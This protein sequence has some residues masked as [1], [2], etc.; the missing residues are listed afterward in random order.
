[1]AL[2]KL[3]P[4]GYEYLTG[5]VA[6]HDHPLEPGESLA[7]Y[8]LAHGYPPGQWFG[9]GAEQLGVTGEV[10]AAQMMALFGE[11]RHPLAD[12][13]EADL[14]AAG[15]SPE[16]ALTATKLGYRFPQY[17]G[18]DTLRRRVAQAYKDHNRATGRPDNAPLPDDVR[19]TIRRTV[20]ETAFTDA[21]QG[22][23]PADA[24]ELARWL[25][26]QK[27]EL[28]SAVAGYEAVFA[29]P[30]SVSVAWA[31]A[32]RATADTI[33]TAHRESV[34]DALR[35]LETNAAFTRKGSAGIAQVDV[36]GITAAQ[37][38]H[39]DSR[40]GD[41]HL[42][43]H[44]PI[45]TK[46]QN[47]A[48]EWTS[49]DGRSILAATVTISEYYNSR[50]RDHLRD[51]GATWIQRPTNG[52]DITRPVWELA[53]VP[54]ELIVA[55]SR[56]SAQVDAARAAGIVAFRNR[57]GHE[58]NPRE[59]LELGRRAQ[60]GTRT[61]KTAPRTLAQHRA[62]W[63]AFA[64]ETIGA[65]ARE[66][67]GHDVL[68]GRVA[69][70][71]EVNVA[72][73]AERTRHVVS[74]HRATFTRWNLEAEAHRQTAH[75]PLAPDTHAAAVT[76][77]VQAILDAED[78]VTLQA[79]TLVAEPAALRRRDGESVFT[80]HNATR[81]TTHTTLREEAALVAAAQR[82][83]G[84]R[85]DLATVAVA[86]DASARRGVH[87]NPAQQRLVAEFAASGRRVQL[88]LAPAGT[89]KTTAMRVFA[90]AWRA[91]GGRVFAFAPSARA[92]QELA[93]AIGARPHTLHQVPTALFHGTAQRSFGFRQGDVVI[94][95]EAA[96]SGTHTLHTVIH[97]V[98]DQGA[99]VRLVG[100]D[101][102]LAAVEA[103]GAIRLIAQDVGAL[104]LHE[105]VRFTDSDQ[106]TA[107]LQ[108]RE[109]HPHGLKYYLRKGW[110]EGG[111][112]ETMRDAAQQA[113]R[114]DLDA[115]LQSLLIAPALDDV[116]AL[117]LQ[118]R[119]QRAARGDID[120]HRDVALHDGTRAG[121]HD[122]IVTRHNDRTLTVLRGKDFVKNGD[123]WDVL[124]VSR[125]GELRVQHRTHGARA[126]LPARYVRTHVELAYAA[127]IHRVQGMTVA[128]RA[129]TVIPPGMTREQF[130]P[131]ITRAQGENRMYVVTTHHVADS[132]QETPDEVTARGVLTGILNR[133]GTEASATE[134]LRAA[135]HEE[136]SLATLVPRY[137][138]AA[139]LASTQRYK[140]LLSQHLPAALDAD[141][142][143]A[144]LQTMRTIDS[145]GW[146]A[147][148][149]IP[150][151]VA[152]HDFLDAQDPAAV[153]IHRVQRHTAAYRPPARIANPTTEEAQRWRA[154]VTKHN[155][156]LDV[157]DDR[158][159]TVCQHGAAGSLDAVDADTA[160]NHAALDVATQPTNGPV[161][162]HRA[163][164]S[165]VL[166]AQH[167]ERLS[168]NLALP[169]M[170]RHN[171]AALDPT[172][173]LDHYLTATNTTIATRTTEL[174][175]HVVHTQP[176]WAATLDTR[177]TDHHSAARW[178]RL[179]GL[180][181]AYRETFHITTTSPDQPLGPEPADTTPQAPAWRQITTMWEHI[182]TARNTPDS[183]T[184]E[185][186]IHQLYEQVNNHE[187]L[188]RRTAPRQRHH[189]DTPDDYEDADALDHHTSHHQGT[190]Y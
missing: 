123:T 59:L 182:T 67:L 155:P 18:E 37:F 8:Y 7:D 22:Q 78:T 81:Y 68:A 118:A 36:R 144:L 82:T 109:G 61:A 88:A 186:R 176:P 74:D 101:Q 27:R 55:F 103:G 99:D 56:R 140:N 52:I 143:P 70:A 6:C 97:H 117:N 51:A 154:I 190:G 21:H 89:G 172:T 150:M 76:S 86:L 43:T 34:T 107:S 23:A 96:M 31:L 50:L 58:P 17:G 30:K 104:R 100:D 72:E 179:I 178:D 62:R 189:T 20:T 130:Y 87:L 45:S 171:L 29:P 114:A 127:T 42:H 1:M 175:E 181:A 28:R 135:L 91:Q 145:I 5:T 57:H 85:V 113:W 25:A 48:G 147:E 138:H 166:A 129:H 90:D 152:V 174:V 24:A 106:A 146:Q 137:N 169:W 11:G 139:D 49:L 132:H 2:R 119:A 188:D 9:T 93:A 120:T 153:L 158:W 77:V 105:V 157:H 47:D 133:P 187:R 151:L 10:T 98:L 46:V 149:L 184:T 131:T 32:D 64:D 161:P 83:G 111:S 71:A 142:L 170:A 63:R 54:T 16:K 14:L 92:A 164:A 128:H 124:T 65:T 177:P 39:W 112:I 167:D 115:G 33:A 162:A 121:R 173:D 180:A 126:T 35:Y 141:A 44:V 26:E 122:W 19:A 41:P 148:R 73:L 53:G 40:T 94:I 3:T 66:Q 136:E 163:A 160:I 75:L 84:H 110:V 69:D 168:E 116:V 125:D 156:G 38:E 183:A 80:Q 15:T 134:Q 60:Y 159:A 108:I 185:L 4:G 95:D 79:P 12:S 13:I 102:Q 165:A